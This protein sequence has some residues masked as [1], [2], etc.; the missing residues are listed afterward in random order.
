MRKATDTKRELEV[1]VS[2]VRW[3]GGGDTGWSLRI[4]DKA[5]RLSVIEVKLSNEQ[6]GQMVG[7]MA[8][9]VPA[10]YWANDNIGRT[11]ETGTVIAPLTYKDFP[12]M[13][14]P[15]DNLADLEDDRSMKVQRAMV[16]Q[17]FSPLHGWE[18]ETLDRVNGHRLSA[19]GYAVSVCR[20]VGFV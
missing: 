19:E 2:L 13:D 16:E 20:W 9:T 6:F 4:E 10:D 5:S 12:K 17:G 15:E 18:H 1:D 8:T 3:S 7:S 11:L 14:T